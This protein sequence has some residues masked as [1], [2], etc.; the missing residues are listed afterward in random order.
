[1]YRQSHSSFGKLHWL[2]R[3]TNKC[4]VSRPK[5]RKT[6]ERKNVCK[7]KNKKKV[8]EEIDK[9]EVVGWLLNVSATCYCI[10]GTDLLRQLYVLP[11]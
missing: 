2:R 6:V 1:M 9:K 4:Q 10:S 3:F 5:D 7:K 11:R 8:M